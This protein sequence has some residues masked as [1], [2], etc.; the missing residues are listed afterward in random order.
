VARTAN[1]EADAFDFTAVPWLGRDRDISTAVSVNGF[2]QVRLAPPSKA[3]NSYVGFGQ[4]KPV[5]DVS[6]LA[7]AVR[8][9]IAIGDDCGWSIA[10]WSRPIAPA[11]L[12]QA[13]Q[14][15]K[16]R[17]GRQDTAVLLGEAFTDTAIQQMAQLDD[18][19]ILHFAT[20]GLVTPRPRCPARP[21]LLTSFGGEQSDGLLSFSEIFDLKIDAD[22]VI[23]SAC[24]TA[25]EASATVTR[26]AGVTTGGDSALDGLVRAFVAAGGRS[27]IASHWPVPDTFNATERLISGMFVSPAGVPIAAS[28][29]KSQQA[30][31]NDPATSHPFYWA[32][33]AIVGDGA[34]PMIR[35]QETAS[36]VAASK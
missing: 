8:A 20:H 26:E 34:A 9:S 33:F 15:L 32:A 1:P 14:T 7:P 24:D 16:Q 35:A 6:E 19:R 11:E 30:L 25:G 27:V 36:L 29:R 4:N 22:L 23:L 18:Y 31:M 2:R 21:A 12:I 17:G 28:L 10:E 3:T 5:G 13:S